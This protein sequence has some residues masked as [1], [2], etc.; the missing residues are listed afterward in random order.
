MKVL[1]GIAIAYLGISS[2]S[3]HKEHRFIFPVIPLILILSVY[4]L[5]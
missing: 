3:G 2:L 5:K 1:V 4:C